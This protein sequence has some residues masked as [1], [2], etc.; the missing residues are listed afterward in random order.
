MLHTSHGD[1]PLKITYNALV[2]YEERFKRPFLADAKRTGIVT[3]RQLYWAS[4]LHLGKNLTMQQ[5]GDWI[6]DAILQGADLIELQD[7]IGKAVDDALFIQRLAEKSA[8]RLA[9]K[10]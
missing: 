5:V 1:Y 9:E 3:I 2:E 8:R 10:Q 6:E 7:E 4:L